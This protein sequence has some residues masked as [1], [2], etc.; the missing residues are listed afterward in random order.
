MNDSNFFKFYYD[1]FCTHVHNGHRQYINKY[2]LKQTEVYDPR[3]IDFAPEILDMIL[4]LIANKNHVITPRTK[5]REDGVLEKLQTFYDNDIKIGIKD[6]VNI[7]Y[8]PDQDLDYSLKMLNRMRLIIY[9]TDCMVR[10]EIE[11]HDEIKLIDSGLSLY[12]RLKYNYNKFEDENEIV[13][14]MSFER[15]AFIMNY[16]IENLTETNKLRKCAKIAHVI[17]M[18]DNFMEVKAKS[19]LM[20]YEPMYKIRDNPMI[21][22]IYDLFE[23]NGYGAKFKDMMMSF[24]E[25]ENSP[26]IYPEG[27]NPVILSEKELERK[28]L[29]VIW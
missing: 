11:S 18:K 17:D 19:P 24:K 12:S 21:H 16:F 7:Y 1:E 15:G 23:A 10:R 3:N 5:L 25:I 14:D 8:H 27:I 4:F 28:I 26:M 9:M 20:E 22:T 6:F 29:D 2:L 13:Q